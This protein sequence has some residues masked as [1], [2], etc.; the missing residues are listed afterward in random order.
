[1]S[2]VRESE[3]FAMSVVLDCDCTA[4]TILEWHKIM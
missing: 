4:R 2:V 1:V 3:G